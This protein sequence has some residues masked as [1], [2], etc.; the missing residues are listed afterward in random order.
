MLEKT[1][2]PQSSQVEGMKEITL[3]KNVTKSILKTK[4]LLR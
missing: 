1:G 4:K 2:N 3:I